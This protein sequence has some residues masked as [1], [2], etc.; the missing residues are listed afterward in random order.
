[1]PT[2][3]EDLIYIGIKGSV[4]AL[5]RATGVTRW[6]TS[7]KG[8]GFVNLVRDQNILIA[9]TKGEIFCLDPV[10]GSIIWNNGLKGA[11]FGIATIVT[12]DAQQNTAAI[13][14]EDRQEQ[15]RKSAD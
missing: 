1:M 5:D 14:E 6:S 10:T 7:L 8:F 15:Q 12:G 4:H 11:G 13:V 9:G 2:A 3:I